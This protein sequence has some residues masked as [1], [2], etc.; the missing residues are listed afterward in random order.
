MAILAAKLY[1]PA[2]AVLKATSSLLAMTALDTTNLRHTVTVPA[3][4]LIVCHLRCVVQG[5]TTFPQVLLG[6]MEGATVVGRA[7]PQAVVGGTATATTWLVLEA[8]IPVSLSAGSHTLDAA[9]AVET[10][11]A[12]TNIKY[13][14]PNNATANDAF[15]GLMFNIYS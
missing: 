7:A 15:G 2:A 1:D 12:S 11:L 14:G 3:S 9:Y 13:G 8:F 10:L 5:A 6:V 4:G